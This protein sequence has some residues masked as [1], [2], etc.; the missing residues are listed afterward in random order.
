MV[1]VEVEEVAAGLALGDGH[2][3]E[4]VGAAHRRAV[5]RREESEVQPAAPHPVP[6][7]VVESG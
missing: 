2:R 6:L 7:R 3:C 1:L 5:G 4:L